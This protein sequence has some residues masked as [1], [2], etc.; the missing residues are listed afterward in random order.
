MPRSGDT[1]PVANNAIQPKPTP[2]R[3]A[4]AMLLFP[5]RVIDRFPPFGMTMLGHSVRTCS[6]LLLFFLSARDAPWQNEGLAIERNVCGGESVHLHRS[7]DH[8][9]ECLAARRRAQV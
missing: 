3:P 4:T 7:R 8:H 9:L 5:S 1:T 2:A 6:G